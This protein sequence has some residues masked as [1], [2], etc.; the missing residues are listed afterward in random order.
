MAEQKI[1]LRTIRDFGENL[2]DTFVFL[3]QHSK[4]LLRSFLAICSIFLV[5]LGI[6]SSAYESRTTR[7]I[8]SVLTD[9]GSQGFN[10][11]KSIF[12]IN[13]FMVI[14]MTLL[15]LVSMKVVV[16]VY[17]KYYAETGTQPGIQEV[18][19]LFKKYFLKVFL[20]S[21]LA[22]I[23]I[24]VGFLFCFLPG[25]YLAVVLAPLSLV[26]VVEDK[27]FIDAYQRCLELIKENF[28]P[29]L[30]LYIVAYIM[31]AFGAGIISGSLSIIGL[32][33]GYLTTSDLGIYVVAVTSFIKSF[34][35]LFYIIY[36]VCMAL[37]Y[38]SLVERRD[39]TGMLSRID[40][41]GNNTGSLPIEEQF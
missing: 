40:N 15:T 32:L 19:T 23:S 4:T 25:I 3:R 24:V 34:S 21:F 2:S 17:M 20:F 7:I 10:R 8:R 16:T 26:I 12:N 38:F 39:G 9:G 30:G 22:Y 13:Y 18:W 33:A 6:F 5:V 14:I 36:F 27:G 37:N 31:Y 1:E 11:L 41:I 28:W 29:S 35:L